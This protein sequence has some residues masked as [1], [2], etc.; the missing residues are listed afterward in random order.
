MTTEHSTCES[1]SSTSCPAKQQNPEETLDQFLERQALTENL[2]RIKHKIMVMSGKGGVGK[3]TVAV[4]LAMVLA[5]AGKRV[6]LMDV[7]V[8]GPSITGLLGLEG[9]PVQTRQD[10]IIPAE[11]N[12]IKVMSVGMLLPDRDAAVIW[13][14]PLKNA[15]I[16]QFLKD[17][18]W[19]DLDYLIIDSPPGTGDEP[20]SVCQLISDATGAVIVTTPQAIAIAD[21]RRSITFCHQLKLPVL[22]IIENMSGFVCPHCGEEIQIF[23]QGG[24]EQ[25]ARETNLP[26]LG[27]IPLD[28]GIVTAGDE[29]ASGWLNDSGSP[30]VKAFQEVVNA[31]EEQV[32]PSPPEE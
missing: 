7:D 27:G 29:G 16:Q 13:R 3:S 25:L 23:K 11:V 10:R 18:E 19:G 31:L 28:P 12:G 22:G 15:M 2:C 24:G 26:F 4:N 32:E 20:L 1:C 17:V 6:G 8:H 5:N 14:G 30:A 21:V 9:V